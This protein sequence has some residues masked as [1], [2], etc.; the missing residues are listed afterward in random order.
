MSVKCSDIISCIEKYAP[1]SLAEE[2]DNV[3]LMVGDCD[4]EISKV[5]VA[6][7]I[8]DEV[9]DEAINIGAEM[10]ITHHPL[11]FK[12]IKSVSSYTP[13]GKRIIKLIKNN[14]AVY[15]AHTNL[16]ISN[17]GT[18]STLAEMLGLIN[19]SNLL[20]TDIDTG[21][22]KIGLLPEEMTFFEFAEKVRDILGAKHITISGD[23]NTPIKKVG[24]CTGSGADMEYMQA[25][26]ES[27]CDVYITGDVGYHDAQ[28][29][30]DLGICIV[31]GTHY[32]T[33][34]P[35]VSVLCKYLS[36][37]VDIECVPSVING[38][39]LNII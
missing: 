30:N 22:G 5:L 39:T 35:V 12:A 17:G 34:V 26:K 10:I 8:N 27:N 13:L 24:I 23:I 21:L 16:D 2:W 14:I 36:D 25:A 19:I 37:K 20:N 9:I 38:Q 15:S 3:G 4:S 1:A 28:I 11:I 32:L 18:N 7:D 31:D 29:A 33:E 6:L